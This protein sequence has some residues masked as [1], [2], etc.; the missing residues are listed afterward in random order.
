MTRITTRLAADEFAALASATDRRLGT[1]NTI[2]RAVVMHPQLGRLELRLVQMVSDW[3]L[4]GH[5]GADTRAMGRH[6]D[7]TVLHGMLDKAVA[8][9]GGAIEQEG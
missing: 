2:R 8:Q 9:C 5:R 3:E 1:S 6:A 4:V 7:V